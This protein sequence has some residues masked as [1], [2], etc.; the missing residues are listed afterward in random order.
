LGL[1]TTDNG[2]YHQWLLYRVD[3][4]CDHLGLKG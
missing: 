1:I 2:V 3:A 4:P